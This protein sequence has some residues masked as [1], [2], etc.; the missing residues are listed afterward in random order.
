MT[1]ACIIT[2]PKPV[3]TCMP[4]DLNGDGRI[5]GKDLMRLQLYLVDKTVILSCSGDLNGDGRITGKDVL[6]L[7]QYLVDKTIVLY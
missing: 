7:Q 3:S 4:G 6:R 5:T 2:V 1:A